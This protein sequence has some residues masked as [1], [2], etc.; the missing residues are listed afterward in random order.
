MIMILKGAGSH[1][2]DITEDIQKH[3]R[4]RHLMG[5]KQV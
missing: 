2:I 1:L 4:I 5:N 3:V